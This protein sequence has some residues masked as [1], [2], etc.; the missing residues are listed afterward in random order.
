MG[1]VENAPENNKHG[2]KSRGKIKKF[3]IR[4]SQNAHDLLEIMAANTGSTRSQI[5]AYTISRVRTDMKSK[6]DV[7]D[8]KQTITLLKKHFVLSLTETISNQLTT[9]AIDYDI[10][11]NVLFG[12]LVSDYIERMDPNSPWLRPVLHPENQNPYKIYMHQS[13]YDEIQDYSTN[14]Y[15]QL[16]IPVAL[17][18]LQGTRSIE[19]YDFNEYIG[20]STTLPI[21]L[22]TH[23]Q[24]ESTKREIP[25]YVYVDSCIREFWGHIKKQT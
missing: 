9:D 23:I 6:D 19:Q 1:R 21:S 3:S 4:L 17:G 20:T 16:K 8:L 24:Q 7:L 15:V 22:I 12:L 5:V 25:E 13:Y 18:V 11:K 2:K 14:E 10:K